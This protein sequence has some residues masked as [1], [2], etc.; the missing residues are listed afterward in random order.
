MLINGATAP[1]LFVQ[2][3]PFYAGLVRLS[4]TFFAATCC[5]IRQVWRFRAS[6]VPI[7]PQGCWAVKRFFVSLCCYIRLPGVWCGLNGSQCGTRRR[8]CQ[9]PDCDFLPVL[10][11]AKISVV[12]Q[13]QKGPDHGRP[14]K[15][16]RRFSGHS[17]GFGLNVGSAIPIWDLANALTYP[18]VSLNTGVCSESV[19]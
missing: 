3:C 6:V 14:F 11:F 12:G 15:H 2:W 10:K 7:V 5:Y 16:L 19:T 1:W 9:A 18:E 4:S 17:F 13:T 8:G